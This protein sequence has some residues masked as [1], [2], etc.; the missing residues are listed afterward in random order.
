MI[1]KDE[2]IDS[3][4]IYVSGRGGVGKSCVV[5]FLKIS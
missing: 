4:K 3:L 5:I 2:K 1:D